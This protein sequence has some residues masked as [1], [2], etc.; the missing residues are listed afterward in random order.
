MCW[1]IINRQRRFPVGLR[2]HGFIEGY[3]FGARVA[4][5]CLG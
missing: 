4:G 1:N 2:E 3:P 5:H